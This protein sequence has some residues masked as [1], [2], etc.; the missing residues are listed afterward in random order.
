[1]LN[2]LTPIPLESGTETPR[3]ITKS[4]NSC[5]LKP[6]SATSSLKTKTSPPIIT[7]TRS[8]RK[9]TGFKGFMF[10]ASPNSTLDF[11]QIADYNTSASS[12]LTVS[13]DL[14]TDASIFPTLKQSPLMNKQKAIWRCSLMMFASKICISTK[15]TMPMSLSTLKSFIFSEVSMIFLGP[16][17]NKCSWNLTFQAVYSSWPSIVFTSLRLDI[18]FSETVCL[19]PIFERC[20]R[21]HTLVFKN[22]EGRYNKIM[23]QLRYLKV[24]QLCHLQI[25]GN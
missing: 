2:N 25:S 5:Q 14:L 7:S 19:K 6:K 21:L 24:F 22:I 17:A 15:T 1:M 8:C 4:S 9:W 11:H 10:T 3:N 23:K 18:I 13:S 16:F 12:Q 20:C